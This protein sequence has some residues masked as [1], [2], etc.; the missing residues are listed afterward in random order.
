MKQL[1]GRGI[2][3]KSRNIQSSCHQPQNLFHNLKTTQEFWTEGKQPKEFNYGRL[4]ILPPEGDLSV[5]GNYR[6]IMML[7]VGQKIILNIMR[8][9]LEPLVEELDY[10]SQCG[11]CPKRGTGDAIFTL[12]M[13]LKKRK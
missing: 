6:G 10:E 4:G 7:E 2:R 13:A 8:I 1:G 11:F 9:S 12:K 5:P 3:N